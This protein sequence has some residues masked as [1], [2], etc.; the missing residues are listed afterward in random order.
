MTL[1]QCLSRG[2]SISG[3][4]SFPGS[5]EAV[6][7]NLFLTFSGMSMY[8]QGTTRKSSSL[9]KCSHSG[10]FI[11]S[12][13]NS[14]SKPLICARRPAVNQVHKSFLLLRDYTG[15]AALFLVFYGAA[16]LYAIPSTRV[17]CFYLVVLALQLLIV[18]HSASNYGLSFVKTVLAQKA[19]SPGSNGTRSRGA[20]KGG[21]E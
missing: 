19:A 21:I 14:A 6:N 20:K 15:M 7:L 4:I 10:K 12:N 13:I 1:S 17:G 16:G 9:L 8:I 3:I 11:S 2:S 5:R 18:R